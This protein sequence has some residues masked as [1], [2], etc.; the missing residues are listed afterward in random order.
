MHVAVI[1]DGTVHSATQWSGS[2][3]L[4]I[5]SGIAVPSLLRDAKAAAKPPH[6]ELID[7]QLGL[8]PQ[9][10]MELETSLATTGFLVPNAWLT[11]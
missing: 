1:A 2:E 8:H 11:T 9:L 3:N 6:L 10:T 5:N 4:M 7:A